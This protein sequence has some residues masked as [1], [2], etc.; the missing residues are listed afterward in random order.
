MPM[1]FPMIEGRLAITE[2]EG[3]VV[4]AGDPAGLRS[5]AR[6]LAWLGDADLEE[7]PYLRPGGHAHI[8]L[9]PKDDLSSE[10]HKV[11]LMR[12]DPKGPAVYLA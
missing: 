6:L 5:F 1:R 10:S 12:L 4:I 2:E 7:W 3:K 11:E 9:Y 8:H